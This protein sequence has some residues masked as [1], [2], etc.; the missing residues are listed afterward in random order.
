MKRITLKD[1]KWGKNE[2]SLLEACINDMG[3]LVLEGVDSGESVK[4]WHED[5]DFEYLH[6]I[7]VEH[8]HDVLLNLIKDRFDNAHDYLKWLEEKEIKC[9]SVSF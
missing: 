8:V 3:D 6:T 4:E 1:K 7:S 9:E 5:F 2:R